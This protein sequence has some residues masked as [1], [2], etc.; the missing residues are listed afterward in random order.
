MKQALSLFIKQLNLISSGILKY[1]DELSSVGV[2]EDTAKKLK[3]K[4]IE[5]E[6]LSAEQHELMGKLKLKTAELNS[7]KKDTLKLY[8]DTKKIIKIKMG[9]S[10]WNTF[11][12]HDKR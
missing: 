6:R 10:S 4:E 2:T 8:S 1:L 3:A 12:I 9:R 11:G 7:V 5:L